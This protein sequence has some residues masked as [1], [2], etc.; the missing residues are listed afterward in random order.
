[1]AD[2]LAALS[3]A[4]AAL[5]FI[6]F[7]MN[8][9]GLYKEIRES[10]QGATEKNARLESLIKDL[11]TIQGMIQPFTA[12]SDVSQRDV[13]AIEDFRRD[14]NKAASDLLK[15]L[16]DLQPKK[17]KGF[18]R[19]ISAW[20][21]YRARKKIASLHEK[22]E[23]RRKT[24]ESALTVDTRTRVLS[25]LGE[26]KKD[27]A[28]NKEEARQMHK[29]SKAAHLATQNAV[30]TAKK[31]LDAK[32]SSTAHDQQSSAQRIEE[33]QEESRLTAIQKD[34][35]AKLSFPEMSTRH[36]NIPPPATGTYGW[37]FKEPDSSSSKDPAMMELRGKFKNWLMGD[38]KVFWISGKPASGK[39]SLMSFIEGHDSLKKSLGQ[40][41]GG[42]T[43]T[44]LSF[45]FWRAGSELQKSI[46][47][48]LRSLLH[49]LLKKRPSTIDDICARDPNLEHSHW[50]H[51]RLLELLR[52]TLKAYQQ[53]DE[54]IVFLIDGLDEFEGDHSY[55]LDVVL[56]AKLM[57]N[58]K[59]CL[60]SRPEAS[61]QRRLAQYSSIRLEDLNFKDIESFVSNKLAAIKIEHPKT[62]I[63]Y[64]ITDRAQ[65]MFLWAA[66]VSTDILDGYQF[67]DDHE[68]LQERV[69][70]LPPGLEPLF[71]QLFAG[72]NK[73]HRDFLLRVFQLFKIYE[74]PPNVAFVTACLHHNEVTT[75]HDFLKHCQKVQDQIK[76]RSKGLLEITAV[77]DRRPALRGW[78]LE[79][80]STRCHRQSALEDDIVRSWM[81]F[82]WPTVNWL[83][84]SA[85]DYIFNSP[86]AD[87]PQWIREID[88][89]QEVLRGTM[90]LFKYGLLI[91]TTN[92]HFRPLHDSISIIRHPLNALTHGQ[93]DGTL[94][95]VYKT[96]DELGGILE[97]SLSEESWLDVDLR[98]NLKYKRDVSSA[99]I[100][101]LSASFWGHILWSNMHDYIHS[102]FGF[103]K[104]TRFAFATPEEGR[105]LLNQRV[106]GHTSIA[107]RRGDVPH[108]GFCKESVARGVVKQNL[109]DLSRSNTVTQH[110]AKFHGKELSDNSSANVVN[111]L[112]Y[113]LDHWQVFMFPSTNERALLQVHVPA[114]HTSE[115]NN[116]DSI[117]PLR[118]LGV[119]KYSHLEELL[120]GLV[121]RYVFHPSPETNAT[122]TK[123]LVSA[124]G[125]ISEYVFKGSLAA[126]LTCRKA[127]VKGISEDV[128]GQL[129][130]RQRRGLTILVQVYFIYLWETAGLNG[131][132]F[133]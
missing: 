75:L 4:A 49:Q 6:D 60:S 59:I 23:G 77:H 125:K 124:P 53:A 111:K 83:H 11:Q 41:S 9:Y 31:E 108:L 7:G 110:N 22:L 42:R 50:T 68:K 105:P 87:L 71:T 18:D 82:A 38:E 2:P 104:R 86:E 91:Y 27:L 92:D 43:L 72:V 96:L 133:S 8:I 121:P 119:G 32:L 127:L 109:V 28:I 39:S 113:L 129:D 58:A 5:Q 81:K 66:L 30:S 36:G 73:G 65:G 24:F 102:R 69:R 17:Q 117:T 34:F 93:V 100:A 57:T 51:S 115:S 74:Q 19:L 76:T 79:D 47:G 26:L 55:L 88:I 12:T 67:H 120:T 116:A 61:L 90:W 40:W 1:M 84:R 85:Y 35:L 78:A 70:E 63:I 128:S 97:T 98:A 20:R 126:F 118:I 52:E 29:E 45:F 46:P 114:L 130:A 56:E 80:P 122:L 112:T 33:R 37:I 3:V 99:L 44:I 95:T 62:Y 21:A 25:Q 14:C 16:Q 13:D 101:R 48:L 107:S 94:A 131:G 123:F 89:A 103:L 10:A 132:I 64:D 106:K 54:C 15:A